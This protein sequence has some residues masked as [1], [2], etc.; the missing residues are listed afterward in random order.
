MA[1]V[2][3]L[4]INVRAKTSGLTKGLRGARRSLANFA[5]S[6]TGIIAGIGSAFGIFKTFQFLMGSLIGHSKEF[7][8]AW[9]KIGKAL[10][11][12]G[13][14]FAK[15]FG[16]A[17]AKGIDR[18]AEWLTTSEAIQDTFSGM[19]EALEFLEPLFDGLQKSFMFWQRAIEKFLTWMM[20]S[21]AEM[22]KASQGFSPAE[23]RAMSI[24]RSGPEF[25]ARKA[26]AQ[27]ATSR[28]YLMDEMLKHQKRIAERVEVPK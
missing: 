14:S 10:A 11:D 13:K 27:K 1:N 28:D 3:D 12:I 24:P 9:A 16:P 2:G 17:L 15:E 6:G 7:R 21:N 19:G 18:L 20:G 4:F 23:V 5:K 8:E 22:Q 26:G 25:E